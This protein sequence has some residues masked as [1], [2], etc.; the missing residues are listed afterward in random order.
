MFSSFLSSK[1]KISVT[2]AQE[3]TYV[4]PS[5]VEDSELWQE[6]LPSPDPLLCGTVLL[7][8][9]NQ[10]AFDRIKVVLE[11]L[12]DAFGGGSSPYETRTTIHKEVCV[13]LGGEVLP[14]GN[15]A[16]NF[17]LIIPSNTAIHQRCN[18]GRVRHFVKAT[19]YL[20]GTLAGSITTP[21]VAFFVIANPSRPGELPLPTNIDIQYVNEHLGPVGV[22]INSPHLTVA[23]LLSVRV[24]LPSPPA[25][26]EIKSINS[27]IH[28]TYEVHYAD[29]RIS[30]P[31]VE[32]HLLTKVSM[33]ASPS[34][35]VPICTTEC[36]TEAP[37]S[38]TA[39]GPE[40]A[41]R[42]LS[43]PL[44]RDP[45][46]TPCCPPRPDSPE[47]DPLPLS[48]LK[49]QEDD[50]VYHR[51]FRCPTDD[52]VR[53]T[54]L[55]G[56][57]DSPIKVSHAL[58]IEIQYR[59][60]D[61]PA[62]VPDYVLTIRKPIQITSCC[63]LWDSLLLPVYAQKSP[64][65]VKRP[66]REACMCTY[67]LETMLDRDGEALQRA[68]SIESSSGEARFLGSARSLKSPSYS[69]ASS[70]ASSLVEEPSPGAQDGGIDG[71]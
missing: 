64:K 22:Q 3:A 44:T 28:Q 43:R 59:L 20:S 14:A 19:G 11:G 63:C 47:S 50:F 48:L 39:S 30:R 67:S 60:V 71:H 13:E 57:N 12:S 34:L 66:L 35:S 41:Q 58:V 46:G 8:L 21:P 54:T 25:P 24:A 9:A 31:P 27:S 36:G 40:P 18:Y 38:S 69:E 62:D 42:F 52:L 4:H 17:S 53:P 68:G 51:M 33:R 26:V 10:R 29:G 15:H 65:I 49:G 7:S 16:Y 23:S 37:E 45:T 61:Q 5:A 32:K 56:C 6:N 70:Y 1:P 2:L 55:A